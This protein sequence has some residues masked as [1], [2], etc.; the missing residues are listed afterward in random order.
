VALRRAG[1]FDTDPYRLAAAHQQDGTEQ[2]N[3][4]H[5]SHIGFTAS[6]GVVHR[7]S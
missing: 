2:P 4:R 3:Q 7:N 1:R 5:A 6:I